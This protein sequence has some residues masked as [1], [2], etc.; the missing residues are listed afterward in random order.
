MV[1][2]DYYNREDFKPTTD[3]PLDKHRPQITDTLQR[4]SPST[5]SIRQRPSSAAVNNRLNG[6][7]TFAPTQTG[8][9]LNS[10]K[11]GTVKPK[12]KKQKPKAKS[13]WID[14][15]FSSSELVEMPV[16]KFNEIIKPLD[17]VR[18]HIAKDERRKGKNK[19]AARNC[20]KR[21]MDV[22]ECLDQGV[23]SLEQRR[24]NLL[25][26]RQRILEETR[27][28]KMK[29]EWLNSYIFQHMRDSNGLPYNQGDFSLQY[30]SD[31]NVYVVPTV[32]VSQQKAK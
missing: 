7:R 22:I 9:K 32:A 19:L 13:M 17:E 24:V 4:L 5:P 2:H 1:E 20:R 15:Q 27:Q 30:T 3:S 11:P 26:E 25:E 28:I 12:L 8:A 16:E 6:G 18:Q 10:P 23:N 21:K 14:F 31:G 29:T